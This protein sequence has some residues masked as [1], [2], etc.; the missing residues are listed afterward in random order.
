MTLTQPLEMELAAALATATRLQKLAWQDIGGDSYNARLAG[1]WYALRWL[2]WYHASGI[3]TGREGVILTCADQDIPI[4]WGTTGFQAIQELLSVIDP[5]WLEY[6]RTLAKGYLDMCQSDPASSRVA[7][8]DDAALAVLALLLRCTEQGDISWK[9][10]TN[11]GIEATANL[12]NH[13]VV[14]GFVSPVDYEDRPIENV[15]AALTLAGATTSFACGT[16]GYRLAE[17]IVALASASFRAKIEFRTAALQA[18]IEFLKQVL[19]S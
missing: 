16:D 14:I 17:Q 11:S 3:T 2:Y 9:V 13:E 7:S 4:V 12:H 5:R 6:F 18:E 8:I 15:I 10:T 19:A 1:R